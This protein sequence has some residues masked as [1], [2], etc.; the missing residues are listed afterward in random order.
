MQL[1]HLF[2]SLGNLVSLFT[3]KP[4]G[5]RSFALLVQHSKADLS[6]DGDWDRP[7]GNIDKAKAYAT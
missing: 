2:L 3:E 6:L 1:G 7:N 4:V 5:D